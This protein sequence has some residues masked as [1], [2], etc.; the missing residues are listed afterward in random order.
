MAMLLT[1]SVHPP[2]GKKRRCLLR[3]NVK[4]RFVVDSGRQYN[5]IHHQKQQTTL[6][7]TIHIRKNNITNQHHSQIT[8]L[9]QL[10]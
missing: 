7:K 3:D 9:K 6:I 4:Q 1:K 2:A 10:T 5:N 8:Q